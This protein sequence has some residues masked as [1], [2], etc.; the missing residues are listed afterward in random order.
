V[1]A[2]KVEKGSLGILTKPASGGIYII[3]ANTL[4]YHLCF[5]ILKIVLSKDCRQVVSHQ[6]SFK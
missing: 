3:N 4:M 5:P 2:I 6:G 1:G